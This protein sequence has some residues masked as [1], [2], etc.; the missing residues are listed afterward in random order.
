ML[1]LAGCSKSADTPATPADLTGRISRITQT[2]SND[3]NNNVSNYVF[4]YNADG[5]VAQ[6]DQIDAGGPSG[7][8]CFNQQASYIVR[9]EVSAYNGDTTVQDSLRLDAQGR[10][11]ADYVLMQDSFRLQTRY[12]YRADGHLDYVTEH[13]GIIPNA[14]LKFTW[15]NGD[16][17]K[18]DAGFIIVSYAYYTDKASRPGDAQMI[19][20]LLLHGRSMFPNAHLIKE[21]NFPGEVPAEYRYTFAGGRIATV[22]RENE[23]SYGTIV[24]TLSYEN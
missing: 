15:E 10:P 21:K 22:T 13:S 18:E 12:F 19:N 5:A 23:G 3:P 11:V 9:M 7:T 24:Q 20:D 6:I 14:T 1:L 2:Y 17:I 4:T 16:R 8:I